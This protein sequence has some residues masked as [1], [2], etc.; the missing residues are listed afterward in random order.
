MC[1]I[2]GTWIIADVVIQQ[3]VHVPKLLIQTLHGE[4][5][6]A[7]QKYKKYDSECDFQSI[8]YDWITYINNYNEILYNTSIKW[9]KKWHWM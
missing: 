8:E 5:M 4:R 6:F 1:A 9:E 3:V 2:E 7:I